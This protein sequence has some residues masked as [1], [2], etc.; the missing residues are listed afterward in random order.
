M[1]RLKCLGYCGYFYRHP[2]FLHS[3]EAALGVFSEFRVIAGRISNRS[4][5]QPFARRFGRYA[6]EPQPSWLPFMTTR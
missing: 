2:P 5:L 6:W 1:P 4:A 3:S